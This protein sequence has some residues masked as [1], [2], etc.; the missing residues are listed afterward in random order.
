MRNRPMRR[1][2]CKSRQ[3]VMGVLAAE[4]NKKE[5]ILGGGREFK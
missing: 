5:Q 4:R 2:L 3:D 1:S